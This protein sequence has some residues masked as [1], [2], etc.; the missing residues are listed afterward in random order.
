MGI[1]PKVLAART[2]TDLIS[3]E[4]PGKKSLDADLS[5]LVAG[6]SEQHVEIMRGELT[7]ILYEATRDDV[8]VSVRA[9]LVPGRDRGPDDPARCAALHVATSQCH[10]G[11]DCCQ[12][13]R[14]RFATRTGGRDN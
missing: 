4:R 7:S 1:L 9:E 5:R 14:L 10:R 8:G 11:R 6:I 2:Q 13:R 3:L 12:S